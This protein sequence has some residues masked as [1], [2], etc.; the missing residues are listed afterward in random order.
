[1]NIVIFGV[2]GIGKRHLESILK[3]KYTK[4]IYLV[5][6]YLNLEGICKKFNDKY[7]TIICFRTYPN[8]I[9]FDFAIIST[10]V[11]SRFKI[12]KKIINETNCKNILLEKIVFNSK[13]HYY[14]INKLSKRNKVNIFINYTRSYSNAYLNLKKS[15]KP[16]DIE[17]MSV[18]GSKWNLGSNSS[19]FINLFS[20][21]TNSNPTKLVFEKIHNRLYKSKRIMYNEI[22]GKIVL[23]NSKNQKLE[24]E[25]NLKYKSFLI[26]IKTNQFVFVINEN[27]NKL[28]R[29]NL[30]DNNCII[31]DFKNE[32]VSSLTKK[33]ITNTINK[34]INRIPS[35]ENSIKNELFFLNMIKHLKSRYKNLL[36]LSLS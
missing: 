1:M 15:I 26:T 4:T 34:N 35:L 28:I 8:K 27:S 29:K 10:N 24:I 36:N 5:D 9:D 12:T 30:K 7:N 22:K 2:G 21:L 3:L 33:L 11:E 18:C 20:L 13:S 32:Y 31:Y 23:L 14:K 17:H 16:N 19:H 6:L 25:D